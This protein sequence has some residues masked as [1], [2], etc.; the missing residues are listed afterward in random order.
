MMGERWRP[1]VAA[2]GRN[3]RDGHYGGYG[4]T[5][6]SLLLAAGVREEELDQVVREAFAVDLYRRGQVSLGKAAEVAGVATKME[7]AAVLARHD[8]CLD[9]TA[10]DAVA[11]ADA[12]A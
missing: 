6:R 4:L 7:M 9:Y 12:L 2:K 3:G 11:D 1:L 10:D 5:S 8:V